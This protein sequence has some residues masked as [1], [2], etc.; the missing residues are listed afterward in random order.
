MD[1]ESSGSTVGFG[2]AI[3]LFSPD[4][5]LVQF[6]SPGGVAVEGGRGGS[7]EQPLQ[8]PRP[9]GTPPEEGNFVPRPLHRSPPIPPDPSL[10][11][12]K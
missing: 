3:A 5:W 11:G 2:R 1:H 9:S 12:T 7:H 10:R 4:F 8:P 6:P